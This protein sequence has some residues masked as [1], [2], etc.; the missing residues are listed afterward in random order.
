ML[1][2]QL[3]HLM[4]WKTLIGSF[5]NLAG[6]LTASSARDDHSLIRAQ[7]DGSRAARDRGESVLLTL[8]VRHEALTVGSV[9]Y[10]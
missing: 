7:N 1:A 2:D 6:D 10:G 9:A 5:G 8:A 4:R 3:H